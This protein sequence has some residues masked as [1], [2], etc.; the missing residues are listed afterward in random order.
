VI[1]SRVKN[2][3]ASEFANYLDYRNRILFVARFAWWMLPICYGIMLLQIV[4]MLL[5]GQFFEAG[6]AARGLYYLPP[7]KAARDRIAPNARDL[8]FGRK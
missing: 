8:A 4:K 7:S 1:G 2:R 6:G 5:N 3:P